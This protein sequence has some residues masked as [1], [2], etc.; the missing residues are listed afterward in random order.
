MVRF[1]SRG[2]VNTIG[3]LI[4]TIG[5]ISFPFWS[6]SDNEIDVE[7]FVFGWDRSFP[8]EANGFNIDRKDIVPL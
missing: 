8:Y 2:I 6:N 5:E 4:L 7:R 3:L 1:G